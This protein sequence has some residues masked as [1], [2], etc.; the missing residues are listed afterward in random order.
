MT[1]IPL[2]RACLFQTTRHARRSLS[3]IGLGR[4]AGSTRGVESAPCSDIA[5]FSACAFGAVEGERGR[6]VQFEVVSPICLPAA[7][8]HAGYPRALH[9][10]KRVGLAGS[11]AVS[12]HSWMIA[13]R[14]FM[15]QVSFNPDVAE[16][17]FILEP[18]ND[19]GPAA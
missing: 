9:T 10:R 3:T 7:R 2:R 13:R 8:G 1:T 18:T 11:S 19:S 5:E 6:L 15:S 4:D 17:I 12:L 14:G 16:E